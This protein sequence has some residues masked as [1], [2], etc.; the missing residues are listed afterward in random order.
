MIKY[1]DKVS[2]DRAK[3]HIFWPRLWFLFLPFFFLSRK[4][5]KK[6][7]KINSKNL[8]QKSCFSAGSYTWW[9]FILYLFCYKICLLHS[10]S[11]TMY[12]CENGEF[13]MVLKES[14]QYK[15]KWINLLSLKAPN[16]GCSVH[17]SHHSSK[18]LDL[19]WLS[20]L[21]VK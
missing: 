5:G 1:N 13:T 6:K 2:K 21:Y 12:Y 4:R 15:K 18:D 14:N 7:R 17:S 9:G 8:D 19:I 16:I 20:S 11:Y 10:F 3:R